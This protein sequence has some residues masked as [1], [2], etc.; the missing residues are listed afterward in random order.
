MFKPE[1]IDLALINTLPF[2]STEIPDLSGSNENSAF[3]LTAADMA[4]M[5]D[6]TRDPAGLRRRMSELMHEVFQNN[7]ARLETECDI[8]RDT[9]RKILRGDRSVT[10]QQLAKFCIGTKRSMNEAYELFLMIGHELSCS[11]KPDYILLCELKNGG[12]ICDYADDMRTNC[13]IFVFND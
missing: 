9:F 12:D 5:P 4:D 7:Y 2:S 3:R 13:N 6:D 1:M 10:Y 11:I 8:K